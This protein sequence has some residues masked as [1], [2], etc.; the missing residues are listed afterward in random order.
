MGRTV[1]LDQIAPVL[2]ELDYPVS[3]ETAVEAFDDVTLRH[4]D[5][6]ENMGDVISQSSD[7]TFDS[8]DDVE[9]ELLILSDVT[10]SDTSRDRTREI[11]QGLTSD[12]MNLLPQHAVGSRTS[13]RDG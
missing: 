5:G 8:A 2:T 13:P 6:V 11:L 4:A 3:R 10:V 1:K 9:N 7:D 12:S